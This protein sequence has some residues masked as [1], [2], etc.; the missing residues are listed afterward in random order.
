MA[1]IARGNRPV[2]FLHA[3][4]DEYLVINTYE[5]YKILSETFL[6]KMFP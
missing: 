3:K 4:L 2:S 5:N 1:E 6:V